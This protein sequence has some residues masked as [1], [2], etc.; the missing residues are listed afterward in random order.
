[1]QRA[2]WTWVR[3]VA[4]LGILALLVQRLGTGPFLAG[5]RSL[6]PAVLLAGL[7][8]T[9]VTTAAAAL[10]WRTVVLALGGRL[11]LRAAVL[12]YYRSQFLNSALPGGIVGDL[13]RG[14]Q[15]GRDGG[16]V[17]RGVRAVVWERVAGQVVF[18][19]LALLVLLGFD[20][21]VRPAVPWVAAA[22]LVVLAF[23]G[24]AP[25]VLADLGRLLSR[26][27]WPVVVATSVV[28]AAGHTAIFLLALAATGSHAPLAAQLPL[29][30]LVLL[31]MTLPLSIGGWGPR[32]GVAAWTF[33]AAG[34]GAAPGVAAATAYGVL[35]LV[36]TLPGALVLGAEWLLGRTPHRLAEAAP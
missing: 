36:A 31:A 35:A 15:H 4:A 6:S 8:L 32:E 9:A 29:A 33:A 27:A 26:R 14:I 20:S 2:A 24:L 16:S 5:L 13:H 23:A 3:R 17:G 22:V 30:V 11:P 25:V 12:A 19:A 18:V 1:M 21:P 10:R 7:G 28:V 34:F